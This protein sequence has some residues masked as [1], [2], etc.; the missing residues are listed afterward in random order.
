M[1][2]RVVLPKM[3][4]RNY[5]EA[6]LS[7]LLMA[8]P[9]RSF[10]QSPPPPAPS[11]SPH[12]VGTNLPT[13]PMQRAPW[14][15]RQVG[16]PTNYVSATRALFECGMADPRGCEYREI[17]IGVAS[18]I[19]WPPDQA[20]PAGGRLKTHGWVLPSEGTRPFAVCWNGLIY[21]IIMIGKAADLKTDVANLATN[22]PLPFGVIPEPVSL[23]SASLLG[24][25][26]CLLL[27]IGEPEL[28]RTC[29]QAQIRRGQERRWPPPAAIRALDEI[30]L[31]DDDP[32]FEW[33]TEWTW[34]L[35]DRATYSHMR[36]DDGIAL[37]SFR[38]LVPV[39]KAVETEAKRRG[40]KRWVR[41]GWG[42]MVPA[43]EPLTLDFLDTLPAL[44]ADHERR[45]TKAK[46]TAAPETG[47]TNTLSKSEQI[48]AL[49]DDLD[50]VSRT[51]WNV[52]EDKTVAALIKEGDSAI[53]PL[54]RCLENDERSLTRWIDIGNN[55][56]GLL[57]ARHPHYIQE[58]ATLTLLTIL[59]TTDVG[60]W[61]TT[62]ELAEAAT[63][64]NKIMAA[65]IRGYWRKLK[66]Q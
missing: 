25:K 36:A 24:I 3:Y 38:A 33:A 34:A 43:E 60:N 21:P 2:K 61:A 45:A 59:Q 1:P 11:T 12:F 8:L 66:T 16:L 17:E 47:I 14:S 31:P 35:F 46:R 22:G 19:R 51:G 23:S 6:V 5:Q 49:I 15:P 26:G 32:F 4:R 13:P 64:A 42:K 50:E 18:T 40:L 27:R 55:D 28:A 63:N 56:L 30:S 29:W 39:Q 65:R 44:L 48:A 53:E 37:A 10:A 9:F 41:D 58:P 52:R 7:L 20:G 62:N 54:L 57:R